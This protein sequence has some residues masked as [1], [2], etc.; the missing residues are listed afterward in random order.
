[1][2]LSADGLDAARRRVCYNHRVSRFLKKHI[3]LP[4]DHGAWIFL[5][6]P[7]AIGIL[8]GGIPKPASFVLALGCM[9]AFLLRQPLTVAVKVHTGRRPASDLGVALFWAVIYGLLALLAVAWLALEGFALLLYLAVPAIPV[10]LIYLRMVSLRKERRQPGVEI[11]AAGVLALAAS[12]AYWVGLGEYDPAGWLLWILV[13]LQSAASIVY[14]YL[15]LAQRDL[16]PLP[17]LAERW[18]LG[19]RAAMYAAFNLL[20]SA[21]LALLDAP[22]RFIALPYL[23]QFLET[24]W[25]TFRPAIGWKATRIGVRQLVVSIAWTLAFMATWPR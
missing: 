22:L 15:R 25:G 12:A 5:L 18:S 6:S 9:F 8:A 3:A 10:F 16:P 20:L 14:A 1:V 19:R 7:L 23:L 13:W 21:I 24:M 4:Q 17:D 11:L 2:I